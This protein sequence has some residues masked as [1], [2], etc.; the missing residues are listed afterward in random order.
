MSS[1]PGDLETLTGMARLTGV[2]IRVQP[3]PGDGR[4]REEQTKQPSRNGGDTEL[5]ASN[6]V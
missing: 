3:V 6:R 4:L 2:P 5:E 1:D